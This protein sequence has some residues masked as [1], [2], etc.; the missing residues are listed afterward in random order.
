VP[1]V[2]A[3]P[4][5]LQF[6]QRALWAGLLAVVTCS[7]VGTWVVVRGMA[8]LGDALSH[9]LLPGL[10]VAFLLGLSPLL[11]ASVSALVMVGALALVGRYGGVSHDTGIG[12]LFVAMLALGVIV[13]SRSD[14][15]LND[16]NA[17][18]FGDVLGVTA[19]DLGPQ[20]VAAVAAVAA[21]V[22]GYRAFLALCFQPAKAATLGLRPGLAHVAML[23]LLALAVTT[24]FRTV[25]ALL[26]FGLLV[27]PPAAAGVLV[28][29]VPVVMALA[30]VLGAAAVVA[31]LVISYHAGT[32]AGATVAM[33]AVAPFF[34]VV[35]CRAGR[36]ALR[37][38]TAWSRRRWS[39]EYPVA[40]LS[41]LSQPEA[42][43]TGPGW[44][45]RR[46]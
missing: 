12:L 23:G 5:A 31:G 18:L 44:L 37:R 32:A 45:G 14:R 13:I 30:V 3:E 16:L 43:T 7:V 22:I 11:G 26:V 6:M 35:A 10:A 41:T 9:G 34:A 25:G 40:S 24:S 1:E 15:Y 29:R 42:A 20:R 38:L 27:G 8:F 28:R 46:T 33:A 21:S 36:A 17:L 39:R 19:A 2:L 4:F